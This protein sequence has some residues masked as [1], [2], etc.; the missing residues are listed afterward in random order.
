MMYPLATG[1]GR[2]PRLPRKSLDNLAAS[3]V[4]FNT[5]L[6][7]DRFV[8]TFALLT[9]TSL[10]SA[11]AL[12]AAMRAASLASSSALRRA[13]SISLLMAA[14]FA[15]PPTSFCPFLRL[16]AFSNHRWQR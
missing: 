13:S 9:G 7:V 6:V 8:I 5:S 15:Q 14:E 3:G 4:A 10:F 11:L 2:R 16:T 12:A 1:Q